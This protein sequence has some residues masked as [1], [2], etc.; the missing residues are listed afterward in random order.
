MIDEEKHFESGA[1]LDNRTEDEKLKDYLFEEVVSSVTPV[2][3]VEK[4]TWRQFPIFNQNGSGSCVAQTMA[5]MLGIM[6][7]LKNN[8]YVHFSATHIYQ[9]RNN[10]PAG[11][12]AG[13]DVFNIAQKGSTLE[14]LC[15]SQN[16]TDAQMDAVKIDTYKEDVGSVFKIGNYIIDPVKDI[17]TI[18]SIIQETGKPV[19]VWFYFNHDEWKTVPEILR[20]LDINNAS[21]HSVTA[22]DFTLYN[23]KKAL[24]IDDSWGTSYGKAGQRIITEDFFK[25]RNFFCAHAM[26]FKFDEKKEETTPEITLF[27][28]TMK[29]GMNDAQVKLLQQKLQ[30]AGFFP[31]NISCTGYFGSITKKAVIAFQTKYALV[32]DGV[33][34]E[35]T[36]LKLNEVFK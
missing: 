26:T 12:M 22:V 24:I 13:I 10:K 17:E 16:M 33:V 11:G 9:R 2:N 19:M 3:W 15:P 29:F 20:E 8:E 14:V 23:G 35:K 27:T 25:V 31:S 1:L 4:K 32:G 5:K 6:Y 34:G 30:S 18:A 28:K 7:W 21:R 36:L